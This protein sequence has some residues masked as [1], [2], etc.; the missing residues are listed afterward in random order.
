MKDNFTSTSLGTI[1][2]ELVDLDGNS[3][4]K[5]IPFEQGDTLVSLLE[6]NYENVVVENGM[7]MTIE[8]LTTAADWSYFISIYVNDEMSMVGVMEIAFEDQMK[9]S[10]VMTEFVYE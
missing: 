8:N 4:S 1:Q 7:L 10:F 6:A 9:I 5:S 3:T 2:I